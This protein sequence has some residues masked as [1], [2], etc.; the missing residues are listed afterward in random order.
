MLLRGRLLARFPVGQT[1]SVVVGLGDKVD[2]HE[3]NPRVHQLL[4]D[5]SRIAVA[6]R[7]SFKRHPVDEAA[8][9]AGTEYFVGHQSFVAA[10]VG[11]TNGDVQLAGQIENGATADSQQNVPRLGC[12]NHAVFDEEEV[13]A[14]P[15]SYS[16]RAA[17]TDI[18]S[19]IVPT[20][21]SARPEL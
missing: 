9:G 4:E 21:G 20:L 5:G 14:G 7:L 13:P 18:Y 15:E 12:I 17:S 19:N 1:G 3:L 16:C 11:F 2:A 6:D 10:K 8:C